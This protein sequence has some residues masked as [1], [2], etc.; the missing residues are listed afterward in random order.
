[1]K[2]TKELRQAFLS[3]FRG[4]DFSRVDVEE[5]LEPYFSAVYD[6]DK[7]YR[8]AL[9]R[10]AQ[11]LIASIKDEDQIRECFSFE[12]EGESLFGWPLHTNEI[13]KLEMMEQKNI[14]QKQGLEKSLAKIQARIWILKHQMTIFDFLEYKKQTG[15]KEA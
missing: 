15:K 14:K 7:A 8:D 4:R 12:W 6:P 9:A 3:T 1:M 2:I 13:K 10:E 5:F 11:R